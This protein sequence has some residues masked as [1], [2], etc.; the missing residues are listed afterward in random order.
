MTDR[1]LQRRAATFEGMEEAL[2][3]GE[4]SRPGGTKQS[5]ARSCVLVA[6]GLAF[7]MIWERLVGKTVAGILMVELDAAGQTTILF[8]LKHGEIVTTI[9]TIGRK[10]ETVEYKNLCFAMRS[11]GDQDKIQPRRRQYFRRVH[12]L[13]Y[14]ADSNDRD[15]I[16]EANQELIKVP[17]EGEMCD[18]AVLVF[19]Q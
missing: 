3:S 2:S 15:R 13:V 6:L 8:K 14:A 5:E 11:T 4:N 9:T 7:T 18:A 10:V 1:G 16:E 12:G 19:Y 17:N